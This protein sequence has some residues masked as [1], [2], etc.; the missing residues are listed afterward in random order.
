MGKGAHRG[1]RAC[2]NPQSVVMTWP[3]PWLS[4]QRRWSPVPGQLSLAQSPSL[5]LCGHTSSPHVPRCQPQKSCVTTQCTLPNNSVSS[6]LF[7]TQGSEGSW[8]PACPGQPPHTPVPRCLSEPFAGLPVPD[9]CRSHCGTLAPDLV[10]TLPSLAHD[11]RVRGPPPCLLSWAGSCPAQPSPR[12][13]PAMLA[14]PPFTP[15]A[16]T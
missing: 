3:W 11:P 2:L 6:C 9:A 8:P 7:C 12:V 10:L 1:H 14:F 5:C 15:R 13:P 16:P 4:P